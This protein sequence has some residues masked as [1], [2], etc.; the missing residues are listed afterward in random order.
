M[1]RFIGSLLAS[2]L[3]VEVLFFGCE[4]ATVPNQLSEPK[5]ANHLII[6]EV[7]TLPADK[8]YSYSWVELYNPTNQRI[9]GLHKWTLTYT[10]F[11]GK[12]GTGTDTTIRVSA[13]L[14][15][16]TG[17][18]PDT[19]EPGAFLVLVGDSL[20]LLD[21]TG[22]GPGRGTLASFMAILQ[23]GPGF[24]GGYSFYL[25]ETDELVL[26]DT[27][28][29]AVDV[30]RYGNYVPPSPD[31]YPGNLSAGMIPEWYSLCRYADAYSTGNTANDF[32]MEPKPV[33]MWFSARRHP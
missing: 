4:L 20:R 23:V 14:F 27:S 17:G 33:P 2:A 22:L 7:F 10:L 28:G 15:S 8:F 18:I 6:N 13:R 5:P 21:H 11:R 19:L 32:Y 25:S 9:G 24:V 26:K 3:I 12:T 29:N 31:P 30:V 16:W 1:K